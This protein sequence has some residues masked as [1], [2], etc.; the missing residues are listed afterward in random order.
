MPNSWLLRHLKKSAHWLEARKI[1][2]GF[3][4]DI[5]YASTL[6]G[7]GAYKEVHKTNIPNTVLLITDYRKQFL[8]ELK[9][10]RILSDAG[11]KVVEYYWYQTFDNWVIAL[12]K[13]CRTIS[14]DEEEWAKEEVKKSLLKILSYGVRCGDLQFMAD[15][16]EIVFMDPGSISCFDSSH[17]RE[18]H[19]CAGYKGPDGHYFSVTTSIRVRNE[20]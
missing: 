3:G 12:A 16:N 4:V 17:F 8:E 9:I 18:Q 11:V 20:K 15:G 10:L 1:L 19:A 5:D 6:V 7:S 2:I 13:R 14:E